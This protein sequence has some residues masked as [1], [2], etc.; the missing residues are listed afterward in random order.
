MSVESKLRELL[1]ERILVLDGAWG[2]GGRGENHVSPAGPLLRCRGM[3]RPRV[4]SRR[5]KPGFGGT[6][7]AAREAV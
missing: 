5:A 4:A 3:G 6:A 7:L 2:V 1:A